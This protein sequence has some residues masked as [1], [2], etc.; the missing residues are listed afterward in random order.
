MISPC[1]RKI[2][3][4]SSSDSIHNYWHPLVS[5]LLFHGCERDK[6][7]FQKKKTAS[8]EE[9]TLCHG[10]VGKRLFE[11]K[12]SCVEDLQVLMRQGYHS[13][14]LKRC[15]KLYHSLRYSHSFTSAAISFKVSL[16][17][18]SKEHSMLIYMQASRLARC[19]SKVPSPCLE[20]QRSTNGAHITC[21]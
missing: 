17:L 21:W 12:A 19:T 15:W 9:I 16:S 7:L 1:E 20:L 6:F 14:K 3:I 8:D 4:F 5:R 11:K 10:S 18:A 2:N 13:K